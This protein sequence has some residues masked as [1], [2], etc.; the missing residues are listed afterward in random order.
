[1]G[2][3]ATGVVAVETLATIAAVTTVVGMVTDSKEL[4]HIGSGMALGALGAGIMGL[5]TAAET[6]AGTAGAAGSGAA[7]GGA[8]AAD[9]GAAG[10]SATDAAAT[11]AASGAADA[12]AVTGSVG[13]TAATTYPLPDLATAPTAG[14]AGT[15]AAGGS[16]I[17][18]SAASGAS[19]AATAA[20][21]AGGI[22]APAG[23]S[24]PLG[25]VSPT[26][27]AAP[28]TPSGPSPLE[29]SIQHAIANSSA[30]AQSSSSFFGD[31]FG[32]VGN[33]MN[34]NK[35]LAAGVMN[36]AGGLAQGAANG[37][38]ADR[39]FNLQQQIIDTQRTNANAQPRINMTVNPNA[40][41][42]SKPAQTYPGIIAGARGG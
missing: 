36:M 5:G 19:P 32:K 17:I 42:F 9:A 8:A 30:P 3:V 15:D 11:G 1:M 14:I 31:T 10:A 28:W 16:G 23:A 33:W 24:A 35:T 37:Y 13:G 34:S 27:P 39:N 41:V 7:S 4:K 20:T 21:D 12:G 29:Q 25:P 38:A 6:A 22:A 2:A 40:A 18:N 26:A